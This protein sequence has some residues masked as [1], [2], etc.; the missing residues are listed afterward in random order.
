MHFFLNHLSILC[1]VKLWNARSLCGQLRDD[2]THTNGK[3]VLFLM[4]VSKTMQNTSKSVKKKICFTSKETGRTWNLFLSSLIDNSYFFKKI[5]YGLGTIAVHS[6][7]LEWYLVPHRLSKNPVAWRITDIIYHNIYNNLVHKDYGTYCILFM[8]TN[9]GCIIFS[10]LQKWE[11]LTFSVYKV[12][13]LSLQSKSG[14]DKVWR[15]V[16]SRP[17]YNNALHR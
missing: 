5:M 8:H 17:P 1:W 16:C 7:C 13:F 14:R 9:S 3:H 12:N 6:Q 15:T 4:L 11:R 2:S 10:L